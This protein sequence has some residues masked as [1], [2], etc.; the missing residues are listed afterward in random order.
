M[1]AAK[2]PRVRQVSASLSGI[3]Q[4]VQIIR[5]DGRRVGDI[6]PL[7]RLNVSIVVGEGDK[8]ESGTSGAGGRLAYERFIDPT[9]WKAQVD[10][11]LRQALVNLDIGVRRRPARCRSCSAPA[12]PA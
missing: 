5:A 9:N 10:E 2:D 8:M 6:R 3:W 7:V 12:G 11:A 1:R 4:A